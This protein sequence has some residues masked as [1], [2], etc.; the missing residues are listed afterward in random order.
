MTAA[1]DPHAE[2]RKDML[3]A[4]GAGK[5][6]CSLRAQ[7]EGLLVFQRHLEKPSP[8]ALAQYILE[9]LDEGFPMKSVIL[10]DPPFGTGYELENTDGRGLYI[11]LKFDWP[12]VVIMSFHDTNRPSR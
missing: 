9:L 12:Y 1:D 5:W 4:L 2:I 8:E 10:H 7:L 6:A 3:E 11:K